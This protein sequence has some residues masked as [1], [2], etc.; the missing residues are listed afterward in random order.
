M[1]I[2]YSFLCCV[3]L[4]E[5]I[6]A[7]QCGPKTRSLTVKLFPSPFVPGTRCFLSSND[8]KISGQEKQHTTLVTGS[9][10]SEMEVK[11]SRFIA[12]ASNVG[13]W[14]DAQ[15]YLEQIK[16]EH[17]KAR[18]WCYGFCCGTNPVSE[19]S[20]D[21]GE[22]SGTAGA[23]ILNAIHGEGLS[24]V[25]CVVV[26]YFGGI[27]LGAGGLV[28]AYGGAARQVLRAAPV[29]VLVPKTT[30]HVRVSSVYIGS[31]YEVVAK[32]EGSCGEEEYG[33]DGSLTVAM[34]CDTSYVE[35]VQTNLNDA[36]RG[37]AQILDTT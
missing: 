30:L 16:K 29:R 2:L 34:T 36:T 35:R 9:H 1:N 4:P 22:P 17:S 20:A 3:V 31:V 23:P 27:K 32:V 13:S 5:M 28:R 18:H 15:A 8:G 7:F 12:Y 33:A 24:D 26:R 14:S 21:D 11:K 10:V 19:R 6:P 37:S 25:V